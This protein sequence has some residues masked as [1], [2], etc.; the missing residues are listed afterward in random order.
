VA[1]T[2]LPPARILFGPTAAGK[3]AVAVAL[4]ERLG[5]EIVS[6]D[7]MAVYRGLDAGTAKPTAAERARVPHHCVDVVAPDQPYDVGRWTADAAAA[8]AACAARGRSAVVCGGTGLYLRACERGLAPG[9]PRDPALRAALLARAAR[10]GA[11]ALHAALAAVDPASAG[12]LHPHD[13]RRVVRALEV[14][15]LTGRAL[16]DWHAATRP[17]LPGA[18]I[19]VLARDDATLRARIAARTAAMWAGPLLAECRNLRARGQALAPEPA[20]AVGYREAFAVLDGTLDPAAAAAMTER[21]TWRLTRRQ[22]TW[23]R[24]LRAPV[25]VAVPPDETPEATAARVAAAVPIP[26][27][28]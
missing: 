24:A 21:R 25:V 19:V 12:R 23:A 16:A 17:L 5:A 9:P 2:T 13:V 14:H 10:E 20:N 1:L 18:R 11:A 27:A 8:L 4:A 15:A 6:M 28:P 7:S 3:T 22:A 26:D